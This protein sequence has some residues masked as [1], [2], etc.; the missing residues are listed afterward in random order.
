M[1]SGFPFPSEYTDP[2]GRNRYYRKNLKHLD[3]YICVSSAQLSCAIQMCPRQD[4]QS[5]VF[6]SDQDAVI[7]LSDG[8]MRT[9]IS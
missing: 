9:Y 6:D 2:S 4:H 8:R 1:V 7:G 3:R 5:H